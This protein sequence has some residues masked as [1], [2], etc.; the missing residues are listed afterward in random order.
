[1]P[2]PSKQSFLKPIT[3]ILQKKI[4]KF[5]SMFLFFIHLPFAALV[6]AAVTFF[7]RSFLFWLIITKW[8]HFNN[9]TK[10]VE[11]KAETWLEREMGTD[12]TTYLLLMTNTNIILCAMFSSFALGAAVWNQKPFLMLPFLCY[13]PIILLSHLMNVVEAVIRRDFLEFGVFLALLCKTNGPNV[14]QM[15]LTENIFQFSQ[16]I[17]LDVC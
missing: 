1:M 4:I 17:A 2:K 8:T 11:N 5:F 15:S 12:W 3:M 16:L 9:C 14:I 7:Y 10:E 6:I 13:E